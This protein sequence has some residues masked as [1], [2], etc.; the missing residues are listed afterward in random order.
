MSYEALKLEELGDVGELFSLKGKCALVTGAAGGI[1]RSCAA[2]FAQLG[3]DVAM[4]DVPSRSDILKADADWI[5][6]RFGIKTLPLSGD[7]SREDSVTEF[8]GKAAATLGTLD[9]VFS[10]AGIAGG[11]NRGSDIEMEDWNRIVGINLTGMLLVGRTAAHIMKRDGHGGSVIFTSSMSGTIINKKPQVGARYAPGYPTTK[12][13]VKHLAKS[14]AMDYVEDKIRFNSISPGII[15][16][17]LHDGWDPAIMDEAAKMIPMRRFGS[18]NEIMGV[19]AFLAGD[20]SSY[21]TGTD[22]TV[23]GG[24][25][26]W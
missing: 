21:M 18:L 14:M 10:N 12:A 22:I 16:S 26:V 24:Y 17:G 1:G 2:A 5:G 3:A 23:D 7:V 15:L 9:I 8:M 11:I 13:A 20:L 4:M 19:A 6:E 25:T